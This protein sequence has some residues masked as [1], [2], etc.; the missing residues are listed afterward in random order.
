MHV[1]WAADVMDRPTAYQPRGIRYIL[2][3]TLHVDAEL[4]QHIAYKLVMGRFMH[5]SDA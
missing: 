1:K 5:I 2:C 4:Y 3:V